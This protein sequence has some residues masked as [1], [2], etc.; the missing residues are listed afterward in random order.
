MDGHWRISKHHL[1]WLHRQADIRTLL[2]DMAC[3]KPQDS[4]LRIEYL[5]LHL[6]LI[7]ARIRA[8]CS[9]AVLVSF[10][11]FLVNASAKCMQDDSGTL[12][13]RLAKTTITRLVFREEFT[14]CGNLRGETEQGKTCSF[15][16][17]SNS[18]LFLT[19]RLTSRINIYQL[20]ETVHSL[21][22]KTEAYLRRCYLSDGN[23]SLARSKER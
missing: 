18:S 2:T 9:T 23:I 22:I 14:S 6:W 15:L 8:I 16:F 10:L 4:C 20:M 19:G 7:Y 1:F 21:L 17:L 11:A 5:L 3:W 12:H 13:Y